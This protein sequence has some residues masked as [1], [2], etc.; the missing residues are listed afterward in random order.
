[1]QIK[2]NANRAAKPGATSCSAFSAPP[3]AAPEVAAAR[4]VMSD[5]SMLLKRLLGERSRSSIWHTARSV[6][7]QGGCGTQFEQV[8]GQ[9]AGECRDAMPDGGSLPYRTAMSK[10]RKPRKLA[11]TGMPGRRLRL[12]EVSDTGSGIR[13]T[14]MDKNLEPLLHHQG[15]RQG[16]RARPVHG[17]RDRQAVGRFHL[18]GFADRAGQL[19]SG[20]SLPPRHVPVGRA[21]TRKQPPGREG[22]RSAIINR[23]GP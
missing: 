9:S 3:D 11:L 19:P 8:V 2:Q 17:V 16:D 6:A 1:M 22:R 20:S 18:C 5:L 7:D 10:R 12:V 21:P 14:M 13:P 15:Y 23:R 4:D